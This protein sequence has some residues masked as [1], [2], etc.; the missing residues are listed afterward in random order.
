MCD[1][2]MSFKDQ[3]KHLL[4]ELTVDLSIE[5][6]VDE[7]EVILFYST[8]SSFLGIPTKSRNSIVKS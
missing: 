5:I 4:L 1:E 3:V 7:N 8:K 2:I 6:E